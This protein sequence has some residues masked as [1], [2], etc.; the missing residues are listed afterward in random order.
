MV[1]LNIGTWDIKNS[2]L[3]VNRNEA[4]VNAI[5][6]LLESEE[7]NILGLQEVNPLLAQ[8]LAKRLEELDNGYYISSSFEQTLNPVKNLRIEYNLIVSNLQ[9][10]TNS[11]IIELPSKPMEIRGI[12]DILSIR[13]RNAT[14]QLFRFDSGIFDFYNTHLA[15]NDLGLND[16]QFDTLYN[17]LLGSQIMKRR[18]TILVGNLNVKADGNWMKYY[19][20]MLD[21][22]NLQVVK[23]DNRTYKGHTDNQPVDYII[24]PSIYK[25]DS[26]EC[27]DDYS[28]K[29]S[30]HNPVIAKIRK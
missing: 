15:H 12:D 7:L 14:H 8:M 10:V 28:E 26:V 6:D 24:V 17:S 19:A 25:I 20:K 2:Y 5:I 23:N 18:D 22:I 3:A 16:C 9:S 1:N 30:T 27:I 4:K 13:K 21:K 11:K 29:I